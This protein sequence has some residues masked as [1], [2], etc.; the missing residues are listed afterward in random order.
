M[1]VYFLK[2]GTVYS[3]DFQHG[4][5]YNFVEIERILG[6]VN[7][8]CLDLIF[9]KYDTNYTIEDE[10]EVELGMLRKYGQTTLHGVRTTIHPLYPTFRFTL[11]VCSERA[12]KVYSTKWLAQ[13]PMWLWTMLPDDMNGPVT[14]KDFATTFQVFVKD[15]QR[16]WDIMEKMHG[17]EWTLK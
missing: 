11:H 4:V 5:P 15:E 9:D 7:K 10:L 3:T 1:K 6:D 2:S 16:V 17:L 13:L 12:G 8:M 14:V